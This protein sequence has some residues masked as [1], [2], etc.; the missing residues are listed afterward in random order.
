[1][2]DPNVQPAIGPGRRD[3]IALAA[4][5]FLI[6]LVYLPQLLK[7]RTAME[8]P[9][10]VD[11]SSQWFPAY[12]LVGQSYQQGLFPL[13]NNEQYA[14]L[15]WLAY[16]HTGGLYPP[17]VLLFSTLDFG[18]AVTLSHFFHALI[19]ALGL[20]LLLRSLRAS[21]LS[22]FLAAL[23]F[24]LSGF[25]FFFQSQLSNHA[26]TAWAPLF[27]CLIC[28]LLLAPRPRRFLLTAAAAALMLLAGDV[29]GF[30]Y[31]VIF[32]FFSIIFLVRREKP[33]AL[34][35]RLLI[36]ASALGLGVIIC[37]PLVLSLLE[38]SSKSIRSSASPFQLGFGE[39][40]GMWRFFYH[41]FLPFNEFLKFRPGNAYN[42]GLPPFYMG[43]L[44]LLGF[45]Y[46]LRIYRK[47]D[48]IAALVN[49]AFAMT[50]FLAA[51]KADFLEPL[52]SRIPVIGQL[53]TVERSLEL[54]QLAA[55]MAAALAFDR[56]RS[57]RPRRAV[58]ILCAL[59]A[60]FGVINLALAPD[61]A[62]TT[63]RDLFAALMLIA[64]G[65]GVIAELR[66]GLSARTLAAAMLV[67][68]LGDVYLL[69][70][71]CVPR[72]DKDRF[73]LDPKVQSFIGGQDPN[74]RFMPF[75]KIVPAERKP[76]IAGMISANT[77]LDS[78][79]GIMRLPGWRYF[80]FLLLIDPDV[81]RD[82]A[83]VLTHA[84]E[85]Q[86]RFFTADMYNPAFLSDKNLH[87][88]NLL[89]VKYVFSRGI[90]FKFSSPYSLLN[91]PDLVEEEYGS[92]GGKDAPRVS[93]RL[94]RPQALSHEPIRRDQ[95]RLCL[96]TMFPQKFIFASYV[97]PGAG[98]A[99]ELKPIGTEGEPWRGHVLVSGR[100]ED[101][102][103]FSVLYASSVETTA[104]QEINF[105]IPLD[106]LR[107]QTA[108]FSM[109][110]I[111]DYAQARALVIDPRLVRADA[112]FQRV[113][114]GPL[115][116]FINKNA[117][118]RSFVVHQA[119][120]LSPSDLRMTL[121]DPARF[122]PGRTLLF[123]EG[124]VPEQLLALG[125][126]RG[127]RGPE[128][129]RF[130][131][132][133][134]QMVLLTT[135]LFSPGWLFFSDAYYPGWRARVDG[136]ETRIFRA[137]LVFRAV[138]LTE[139]ERRVSFS[140]QPASFRVGLWA[141]LATLAAALGWAVVAARERRKNY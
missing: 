53:A 41:V 80:E 83:G 111:S 68:A 57:D 13:W 103:L 8:P 122:D 36:A 67:L 114:A 138:F 139:G 56:F 129:V 40:L 70:L 14:G 123:E 120:A 18:D 54:I 77:G 43:V 1:M 34:P 79:V 98:L 4:L 72:T 107:D 89:A 2:I 92:R 115:D 63:S 69:A 17:N 100:G 38:Y 91:E 75:E 130:E 21:S 62:G 102:E 35:V 48:K 137:N 25:F 52:M 55:L 65:A 82:W 42:H 99:F 85:K 3:L 33:G 24:S 105:N 76:E 128:A 45:I 101:Q 140:Y 134:A 61:L 94:P 51:R 141:A 117:L 88:L 30:I 27:L 23:V 39:M 31:N 29:E 95:G 90:S 71:S 93:A 37:S 133:D 87:L 81:A 112:P 47:D 28:R 127:A 104:G 20:Y 74:Y 66:G 32:A 84:P 11:V 12:T 119:L 64:A 96:E 59:A 125:R 106:I 46:A 26:A 9:Q 73:R 19:A 132:R 78:P 135:R 60:V 7:G 121:T 131:R 44:P 49:V 6:A 22:S 15:P 97:Y 10:M 116:I 16:S 110:L 113:E 50:V 86:K 109:E 118:P 126:G 124:D 58:F 136:I 5:V 108:R